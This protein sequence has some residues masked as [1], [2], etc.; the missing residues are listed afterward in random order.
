[1]TGAPRP[2]RRFGDAAL[3]AEVQ[4]SVDAHRL[5]AAV[6]GAPGWP[7]VEDVV[8]GYRS[9]VVVVDPSVAD[10][11]AMEEELAQV[12]PARPGPASA[13]LVKIP[14]RFDGA[15]LEEVADLASTTPAG[16]IDQV[17]GSVLT[18]AFV[19]FLPGFA[20]LEGLPDALAAVPR[21]SSP[22]SAVAAGSVALG[23][24]FAGIYPRAS[25]GGW[26]LVGQTGF[27]LFDPDTP[28]FSTLRPGDTVRLAAVPDA[29]APASAARRSLWSSATR[30]VEIEAPGLLSMVQDLGRRG[31]A[32]LGVPRA[33]AADLWALR[34]ANRLVG[35]PESA[36]ALEVTA[37]GPRLAFRSAAHVAVVGGAEVR[38]DGRPVPADTVVPVAAGQE[39]SV[40]KTLDDLRC[41]IAVG[42]G[43]DIPP[44][45]GSRSSDVLTGLGPGALRAGDVLGLGPPTRP[46]GRL[47]RDPATP[48]PRLV[49]V[50]PGPDELGTDAVARLAAGVWEVGPD[51]DRMGV[52]LVG[53]EP[54]ATTTPGIASRG[55]VTGAVQVPPDGAPVALLC[56]HATVGGYPVV[57]T[58]IGAD[59]G[60]LGQ[61][62][63]GDGLGFLVVDRPA[64]IAAARRTEAAL[65]SRVQGWYPTQPAT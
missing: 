6:S 11:G 52:R 65:A 47:E 35:N 59:L 37:L 45:L 34:A 53:E 62:A 31:V 27:E 16:V 39:L 36:A 46:R 28:P 54:L 44:V 49:R 51:S 12:P 55:T 63:P 23:G 33:G 29:G 10:L 17:V 42:G 26:H 32:R 20:Y 57:A 1:M 30:A 18:V 56:D 19:G 13:R 21:R 61:L 3:V 2:V 38:V 24:G 40:A 58:V 25:P 50:V 14:V 4:T 64:A 7:G 8:V 22:R 41:Y 60:V 43:L 9:V 48:G 15:D 5:A